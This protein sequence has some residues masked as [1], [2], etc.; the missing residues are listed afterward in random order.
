MMHSLNTVIVTRSRVDCPDLNT[1]TRIHVQG[2]TWHSQRNVIRSELNEESAKALLKI[3]AV[4]TRLRHAARNP[5]I[6][7]GL[8]GQAEKGQITASSVYELLGSVVDKFEE[9]EQRQL[10]LKESPLFNHHR[11]YLEELACHLNSNRE[12]TSSFSEVLRVISA[13][14]NQLVNDGF[15][16]SPEPNNVIDVLSNHHLIHVD[17]ETVRFAHQR[18]Q[19]YF[20][21]SRLLGFILDA[22]EQNLPILR[23]AINQP[24]WED[25]LRLVCGMLK[26][27]DS[28]NKARSLLIRIALE[29]DVGFACDLAGACGF[30]EADNSDLYH[31]LVTHINKLCDSSL[32]EMIDYGIICVI[33]SG[34]C[35]FAHRLWPLIESEDQQ[36]RLKTYRLNGGGISLNQLGKSAETRIAAWSPQ[37]RAELIHELSGNPENYAFLVR[38]ANEAIEDEVRAAAIF[39]LAWSF[40]ASDD[41]LR[42]WLNAPLEVQLEQN[43]ISMIAYLLEQGVTN[44]EVNKKLG[45]LSHELKNEEL[46]YRLIITFPKMIQPNA[47]DVVLARLSKNLDVNDTQIMEIMKKRTPDRMYALARELVLSKRRVADWVCDIVLLESVENKFDIFE[48]A[49][50]L[51]DEEE[52]TNFCSEV[53]GPLSNREQTLRSIQK[54]LTC[55]KSSRSELSET[56]KNRDRKLANLL[57][58]A[59]GNDLLSIVIEIGDKSSYEEAVILLDLV[60]YRMNLNENY[61]QDKTNWKPNIESVQSLIATFGAISS[62]EAVPQHKVHLLLCLIAS[63]VAPADFNDFLLEGC[64]LY[65]ESWETYSNIF[66]Q[67]QKSRVGNR[68]INPHLGVYLKSAMENWGFEALPCLVEMLEHPHAHR[69]IPAIIGTIVGEPWQSKKKGM[70]QSIGDNFKDGIERRIA[71][72]VLSQPDETY[73]ETTDVTAKALSTKL[74]GLV[75]QLQSEK[76]SN[77]SEWNEKYAIH[78]M[79]ELLGAVSNIPSQEIVEPIM[80]ALANGHTDI[81]SLVGTLTKLIGQGI[82]IEDPAVAAR[83]EAMFDKEIK[84]EWFDDSKKQMMS[85]L[86]QLMFF[87]KPVS[88]LNKSLSFYVIEWKRFTYIGNIIQQ[89]EL[90]PLEETWGLLLE[91]GK[92]Q[93]LNK[94]SSLQLATALASSLRSVHFNE[95][96]HNI[97]DRTWFKW[98]N[99]NWDLR[100]I[101]PKVLHV[102]EKDNSYLDAFLAACESASVVAADDFACEILSLTPEHDAIRMKYGL[103]AIDSGRIETSGGSP[104]YMLKNMFSLHVPIGDESNYEIHPKACN[105]LR[106]SLLIRAKETNLSATISRKLLLELECQRRE[107]G[108]PSNEPRNPALTEGVA[109]TDV[110]IRT[111]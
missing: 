11:H 54:W 31:D 104:Y 47:I 20:S 106:N 67:W 2:L 70:F 33:T 57:A 16:N 82:F 63:H 109:W 8:L 101:A 46:L 84:A 71:K 86:C 48:K 9:D 78:R 59:P 62:E 55:S 69:L 66:D 96:L 44:D 3:L 17:G 39:A 85:E 105:E 28:H 40:P 15:G 102:I 42:A 13:A 34:I 58:H 98:C 83:I 27:K 100:R 52:P 6:L 68:P 88:L 37:L 103:D 30:S 19:E 87:V 51:L 4:D 12:T 14:A 107:E 10:T 90:I 95:F 97:V 65:L 7:R 21:A 81:Y 108:R 35:G 73:Q 23:E 43:V 56:E 77:N 1:K 111:D 92:T 79:R 53:I 94:E 29:V 76:A 61:E 80:Y 50:T 18:F 60:K 72:R 5:L 99:S 22:N 93:Q 75:G 89:L 25:A 24:F 110:F 91:L 32:P 26:N 38:M 41:T 49:W 74:I 64:R 36:I 45:S